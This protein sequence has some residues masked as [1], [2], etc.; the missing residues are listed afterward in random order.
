M[1][2]SNN[3]E[4]IVNEMARDFCSIVPKTKSEVRKRILNL[5]SSLTE[6]RIGEIEEMP[7]LNTGEFFAGYERF[8]KDVISLLQKDLISKKDKSY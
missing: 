4:E 6:E 7:R 2:S 5:I 1:P 3:L 8:R